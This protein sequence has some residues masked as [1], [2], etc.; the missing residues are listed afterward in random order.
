M[1]DPCPVHSCHILLMLLSNFFQTRQSCLPMQLGAHMIPLPKTP[2]KKKTYK[3]IR[4]RDFCHQR[5]DNPH[6][7]FTIISIIGCPSQ[8][9][10]AIHRIW[11]LPLSR[12]RTK[13]HC[14]F[15]LKTPQEGQG[16]LPPLWGVGGQLWPHVEHVGLLL[17]SEDPPVG[18]QI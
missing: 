9:W 17:E 10:S 7:F 13:S 16:V 11:S 14:P 15:F 12:V 4:S 6:M 8:Q 5:L 2:D 18:A 1:A 3:L